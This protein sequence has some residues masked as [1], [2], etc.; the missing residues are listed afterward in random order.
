MKAVLACALL[1]AVILSLEAAPY[2]TEK[3]SSLRMITLAK[4]G[5]GKLHDIWSICSKS[6][7]LY[8]FYTL[9]VNC[10]RVYTILSVAASLF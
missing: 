1:G 9:H 7:K 2:Q 8:S 3:N 10:L 4:K 5:D 6:A